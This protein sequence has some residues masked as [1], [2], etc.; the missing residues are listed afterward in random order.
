M[1]KG[2]DFKM[3]AEIN[4]DNVVRKVVDRHASNARVIDERNAAADIRKF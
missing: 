2:G 1:R 3:I 4:E